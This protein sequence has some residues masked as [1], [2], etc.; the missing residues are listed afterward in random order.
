CTAVALS[1]SCKKTSPPAPT[2]T[3]ELSVTTYDF[4]SWGVDTMTFDVTS[5]QAWTVEVP[6]W[7]TVSPA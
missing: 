1:A 6:E 4:A 2:L 7:C 5:N 3:L